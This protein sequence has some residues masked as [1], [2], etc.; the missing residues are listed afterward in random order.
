MEGETLCEVKEEKVE[1]AMPS[2]ITPY[3]NA[4]IEE[5]SCTSNSNTFSNA[6]PSQDT[7]AVDPVLYYPRLRDI[8]GGQ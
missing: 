7:M 2:T 8:Q 3:T 1:I 4:L 6:S 5:I